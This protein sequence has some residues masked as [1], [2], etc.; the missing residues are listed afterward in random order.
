[1][2]SNFEEQCHQHVQGILLLLLEDDSMAVRL[3]GIRAMSIFAAKCPAI[4]PRCLRFLIDMLNDEIDEVRVGALHGISRF[5]E[6][7]ILNDYEV[8]TVLFN[9]NE[10]NIKLRSGIYRFF[11]ETIIDR[12][13]ALFMKLIDR[14]IRNLIRYAAQ[15]QHLIFRLMRKLGKSH[16]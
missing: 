9:L 16:S 12:S 2:P 15:D 1:M 3:A 8:E 6:V 5:N 13:L 4:R 11:G 7:L 14:L 10:D